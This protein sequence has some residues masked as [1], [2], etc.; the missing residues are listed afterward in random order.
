MFEDGGT[1]AKAVAY[2]RHSAEDKQENS[3]EIQRDLVTE[4]AEANNIEIIGEESDAGVS[5]LTAARPGFQRLFSNW[6]MNDE[7]P[8]FDYVLVLNNSRWGRFQDPDESASLLKLCK[9]YGKLVVFSDKGL[10]KNGHELT[11]SLINAVSRYMDADYSRK[12]S[13]DVWHGDIKVTQQGFSAGGS[14]PYGYVRVLLDEQHQRE[15]VLKRGEH[16][17]I[18]NQRVTFE[19]ANDVTSETVTRIFDRFVI[20]WRWPDEIAEELNKDGLVSANDTPWNAQKV[21]NILKNQTYTGMLIWNKTWRRLKSPKTFKNPISEWVMTAGA[22]EGLVTPEIYQKAQ[23]RLYWMSPVRRNGGKAIIRHA[24]REI[25]KLI[26][27]LELFDEDER[28]DM[29]KKAPILLGVTQLNHGTVSQRYFQITEPLREYESVIGVSLD[30][31]RKG[32]IDKCF[33]IKT[34]AFGVGNYYIA[35]E[36]DTAGDH[37]L[38]PSN[39]IKATVKDLIAKSL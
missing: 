7:A 18:S 2:Y 35:K 17:V 24:T 4:F 10:P 5:G 30:A 3:I 16:K 14:A 6:V 34:S 20:N 9:D 37:L 15:R 12:L 8:S 27:S 29:Y 23:D 21:L 31:N 38:L 25:Y 11:D 32:A 1:R 22:F 28:F 13:N 19:P 26:D 33:L 36:F 39:Q